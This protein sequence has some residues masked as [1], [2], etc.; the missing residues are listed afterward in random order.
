MNA[1]NISKVQTYKGITTIRAEIRELLARIGIY[2]YII[3]WNNEENWARIS[4]EYNGKKIEKILKTQ[5]SSRNN[6][7]ALKCWLHD[8]I[9]N[10]E[11]GL[12][13]FEESFS[14]Y[15]KLEGSFDKA[16]HAKTP[17]TILGVTETD[18]MAGIEREFKRQAFLW[19]PDKHQNDVIAEERFKEINEAWQKIKKVRGFI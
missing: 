2:T 5:T 1:K 14:G 13:T 19:H 15:L 16:E 7:Q 3:D 4:F 9:K 8:R 17:Y 6:L 12:E 11:R 18:D 10:M